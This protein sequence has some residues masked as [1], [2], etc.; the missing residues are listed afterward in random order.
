MKRKLLRTLVVSEECL[1]STARKE[2]QDAHFPLREKG[3][4]LASKGKVAIVLVING[5]KAQGAAGDFDVV[6]SEST[7][8]LTESLETLLLDDQRFIRVIYSFFT[9]QY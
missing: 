6:N 1:T 9:F 7:E 3:L 5:T 4:Q 2:K 8:N